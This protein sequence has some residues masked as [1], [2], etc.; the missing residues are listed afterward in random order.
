LRQHNRRLPRDLEMIATKVPA[1]DPNDRRDTASE[2][3][4]KAQR[5]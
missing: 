4:D 1:K 5:F 3:R 2:F